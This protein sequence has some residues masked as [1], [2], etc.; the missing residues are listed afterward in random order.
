MIGPPRGLVVSYLLL[1]GKANRLRR[2]A[3]QRLNVPAPIGEGNPDLDGLALTAGCQGVGGVRRTR[4]VRICAPIVGGPLKPELHPVQTVSVLYFRRIRREDLSD[5][6][7]AID[8]RRSTSRHV[9]RPGPFAQRKLVC[10]GHRTE[11]GPI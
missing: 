6:R 4:D 5:L 10:G 1:S 7:R 3:G 11:I 9:G 2:D 8:D